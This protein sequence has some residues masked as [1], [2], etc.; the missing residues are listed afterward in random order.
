PG[1]AAVER[2]GG[3][4]ASPRSQR[5]GRRRRDCRVAAER[6]GALD[7]HPPGAPGRA[8]HGGHGG[9]GGGGWGGRKRAGAAEVVPGV[10]RGRCGAEVV[11]GDSAGPASWRRQVYGVGHAAVAVRLAPGRWAELR[12]VPA[13]T[14]SGGWF[15]VTL[16]LALLGPCA[17]AFAAWG[18]RMA[19]QP[20]R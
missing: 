7:P 5:L 9:G 12:V 20:R 3:G 13:E 11:P 18:A 4:R 17:A 8:R 19:T 10:L 6:G 1:G 16:G 15:A 2:R 14:G